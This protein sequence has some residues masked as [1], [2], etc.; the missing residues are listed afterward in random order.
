MKGSQKRGKQGHYL[1]PA[2]QAGPAAGVGPIV[3]APTCPDEQPLPMDAEARQENFRCTLRRLRT[4]KVELQPLKW[5]LNTGLQVPGTW[6]VV[7]GTWYRV[8][9]T[10]TWH[11]QIEDWHRKSRLRS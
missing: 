5:T 2:L 6:Y 10:G 7:P 11:V 8:P 3:I 4:N 9:G 1:I